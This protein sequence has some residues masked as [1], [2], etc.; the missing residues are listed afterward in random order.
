MNRWA[1]VLLACVAL[2]SLAVLEIGV[3]RAEDPIYYVYEAVLEGQPNG[4]PVFFLAGGQTANA[5]IYF[6]FVVGSPE[7][8]TVHAGKMSVAPKDVVVCTCPDDHES[9]YCN[10]IAK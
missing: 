7:P 4:A 2:A 3:V 6:S 8:G 9:C 10:F 5:K 1:K